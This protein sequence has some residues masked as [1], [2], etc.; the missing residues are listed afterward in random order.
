MYFLAI[1]Y[2][3]EIVVCNMVRIYEDGTTESFYHPTDK[4]N[5]LKEQQRFETLNQPSVCNKLFLQ[6]FLMMFVSQKGNTMKT[7][8]FIIFLRIKQKE[9]G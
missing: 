3:C 7:L 1:E 2:Q 4:I 9:L 6:N 5:I 8:L